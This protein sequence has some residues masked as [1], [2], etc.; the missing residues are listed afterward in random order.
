MKL[1]IT[2]FALFLVLLS[3]NCYPA[4]Q[5]AEELVWSCTDETPS[6]RVFCMAYMAGMLDAYTVISG[7]YPQA[8]FACIPETGISGEQVMNIFI[9]WVKDHPEK[10]HIPARTIVLLSLRDA[11]PCK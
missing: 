2:I 4:M 6:S 1:V 3:S 10:Q 7:L 11:F 5:R 8:K 9:K